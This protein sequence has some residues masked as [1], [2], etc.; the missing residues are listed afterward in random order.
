MIC[1]LLISSHQLQPSI[2]SRGRAMLHRSARKM[3][4]Q[5]L[6]D[7]SEQT[8]R[9]A[10][11][12]LQLPKETAVRR[13]LDSVCPLWPWRQLVRS[14]SC[15]WHGLLHA[16]S[17]HLKVLLTSE[18]CYGEGSGSGAPSLSGNTKQGIVSVLHTQALECRAWKSGELGL[19]W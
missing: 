13:C 3:F 10:A 17:V 5:G 1:Y 7:V 4:I 14:I 11:L 9:A 19:Q 6:P 12:Q 8:E 18:P 16:L 2:L 15:G